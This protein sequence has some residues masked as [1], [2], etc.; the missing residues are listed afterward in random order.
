MENATHMES[1]T[2]ACDKLFTKWL[3]A[4]FQEN[5]PSKIFDL[6]LNEPLCPKCEVIFT[7][8]LKN[9]LLKAF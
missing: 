8:T 6:I 2:N 4:I 7:V 5:F 1:L 9:E 3:K